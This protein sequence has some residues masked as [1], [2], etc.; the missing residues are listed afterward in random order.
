[1]VIPPVALP[2]RPASGV[3]VTAPL[4]PEVNEPVSTP[5]LML[6]LREVATP[7]PDKVQIPLASEANPYPLTAITLLVLVMDGEIVTEGVT[8]K[9]VVPVSVLVP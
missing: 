1:M 5:L 6:Q 2:G 8:V 4:A 9:E 7:A 3:T